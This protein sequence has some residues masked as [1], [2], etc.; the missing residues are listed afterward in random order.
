[1]VDTVSDD[2][3]FS[4]RIYVENVRGHDPAYEVTTEAILRNLL[5]VCCPAELTCR[6]SDERDMKALRRADILV[7]GGLDTALIASE[8]EALKLIQCTSAGVE[9]YAPFDWL[10]A[11]TALTNASGVHADKV[12][13]FGLITTLML[14]ERVPAIAKKQRG[15]LACAY[16][17]KSIEHAKL[18]GNSEPTFDNE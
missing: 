14:H 8:A 4:P 17:L 7:A 12:G 2:W 5:S 13:E 18:I 11:S 6:Y 9:K 15:G 1:M 3:I 10:R 16:W